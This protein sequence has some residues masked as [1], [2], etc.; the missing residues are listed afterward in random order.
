MHPSVQKETATA[1][2]SGPLPD[3]PSGNGLLPNSHSHK[4]VGRSSQEPRSPPQQVCT[5]AGADDAVVPSKEL[6]EEGELAQPS[7]AGAPLKVAKCVHD[8]V[9]MPSP[10]PAIA[11]AKPESKPAKL[12]HADAAP[13]STA[14]QSR[15]PNLAR[16]GAKARPAKLASGKTGTHARRPPVAKSAPAGKEAA[17]VEKPKPVLIRD[18]F[19]KFARKT[20]EPVSGPVKRRWPAGTKPSSAGP[21]F[22]RAL[23]AA[24]K[25]MHTPQQANCPRS[26]SSPAGHASNL[27]SKA[28]ALVRSTQ[29]P[30]NVKKGPSGRSGSK[31]GNP[32]GGSHIAQDVKAQARKLSSEDLQTIEAVTKSAKRKGEPP[33]SPLPAKRN[34]S[35]S[36]QSTS[37][38]SQGTSSDRS[39]QSDSDQ[40][41]NSS[42]ETPHGATGKA[43]GVAA[44]PRLP[45]FGLPFVSCSLAERVKA[46]HQVEASTKGPTPI[47]VTMEQGASRRRGRPPKRLTRQR[48]GPSGVRLARS[49]LDAALRQPSQ[50]ESA[51]EES[52]A[53]ESGDDSDE[54]EA[55]HAEMEDPSPLSSGGTPQEDIKVRCS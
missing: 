12:C 39:G 32:V 11:Q 33:D 44:G 3:V 23:V 9:F 20:P 47:G 38:S 49:K 36:S 27:V 10:P 7:P 45:N 53:S 40:E 51:C 21:T 6:L 4:E 42:K 28:S 31:P 26:V 55:E 30:L 1:I 16:P 34:T 18:K 13:R 2:L 5:S 8:P 17:T 29:S 43:T 35:V 14:V 15:G 41:T 54:D 37:S 48:R 50:K 25:G 24:R 22:K 52:E 46:K 19:G